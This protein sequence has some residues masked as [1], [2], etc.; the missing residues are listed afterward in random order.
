MITTYNKPLR[1]IAND[2]STSTAT[3]RR[4]AARGCDWDGTEKEIAAWIL[5][6]VSS[7]SKGMREKVYKHFPPPRARQDSK[8]EPDEL[9]L[10]D[11]GAMAERSID[12]EAQVAKLKAGDIEKALT[13]QKEL[14]DLD[15][16]TASLE[17]KTHA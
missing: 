3:V 15:A 13:L 16:L 4:Y 5:K 7:K 6:R 2:W 11:F 14:N 12:L 8:Q 17:A 10:R 9:N 1:Q